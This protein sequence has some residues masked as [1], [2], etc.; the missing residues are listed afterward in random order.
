MDHSFDS[1]RI[2]ELLAAH[3]QN[4][5]RIPPEDDEGNASAAKPHM[6]FPKEFNRKYL[7][8]LDRR[9]AIVLLVIMLLEPA[10][11]I[12]LILNHPPSTNEKYVAKLQSKY[13]ELFLQDFVVETPA[14]DRPKNELLVFAKEY[15][16]NLAGEAFGT[17][18]AFSVPA[19]GEGTRE[20]RTGTREAR[21]AR[22]LSSTT[23][24]GRA[25]EALSEQVGRV[26]V[27]GIITGG[28]T[29]L[30]N[31]EPVEQILN[32]AE[33]NAVDLEKKLSEVRILKV[34]RAGT[35]YFG[36]VI[37]SS[38]GGDIQPEKIM[39][40]QRQVRGQRETEAGVSAEDLVGALAAAPEKRVAAH[41]NFEK[42][43]EVPRLIDGRARNVTAGL[44]GLR[45][46]AEIEQASREPKVLKE[47]VLAHNPA[48]QDC[49]RAQL[50]NNAQ[51]K[52]KVEVRLK[53]SPQGYVKE[54]G[55]IASTIDLPELEHCILTKIARWKDFGKVDSSL[56]DVTLRQT[57]VFGY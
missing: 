27:L 47:I 13:V 50:K 39:L 54:V 29:G 23:S 22:R 33:V 42:V 40:A 51:L 35:D 45:A 2:Q 49:Y 19:P 7:R 55:I 57:Y 24:R 44:D 31:T 15:A 21:E 4:R 26:G 48:I 25:R 30:I 46:R 8:S 11:I 28:G 1:A 5:K 12:Y 18:P 6:P 53:I 10:L 14:P 16:E 56:G 34:P 52:G 41:R 37:G 43:A 20:T 3:H 38:L 9:F 32:F 36:S 17:A